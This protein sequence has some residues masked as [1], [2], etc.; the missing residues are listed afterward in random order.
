MRK[1]QILEIGNRALAAGG[2]ADLDLAEIANEVGIKPSSLRY[3]F[4]NREDLAEAIFHK[5]IEDVGASLMAAGQNDTL[6]GMIGTFFQIELDN[7]AGYL[8]GKID[9]RAQ[10]GET[11]TLDRSRRS[12]VAARFM[13]LLERTRKMLEA[14]GVQPRKDSPLLPAQMLLELCFWLPAWIEHFREWEFGSVR[15]DLASLFCHGIAKKEPAFDLSLHRNSRITEMLDT[16]SPQDNFLKAATILVNQRGYRGT[17]IDA[18]SASLGVTKGSFYHH[19]TEKQRLVEQCFHSSYD[20]ISAFQRDASTLDSDPLAA[21]ATVLSAIVN[22]QI[23]DD[24]PLV[25]YSALPGLPNTIRRSTIAGANALDRWF[26]GQLTRAHKSEHVMVDVDPYIATQFMSVFANA[27]YDTV[28]L[29][30]SEPN[31]LLA[32]TILDAIFFGFQT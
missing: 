21:I 10:I 3:Y 18:I 32:G 16:A 20:R 23:S 5:R 19:H 7:Y 14:R 8:K 2:I 22:A 15:D 27:A 30:R 28:K 1:A 26:V 25:R 4:K 31:E 29:Y 13:T 12:R 11:R 24:A 6:T 17:S 9:R